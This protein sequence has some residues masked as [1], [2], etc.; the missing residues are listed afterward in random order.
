MKPEQIEQIAKIVERVIQ[1]HVQKAQKAAPPEK[2]LLAIIGATQIELE[3]PLQ[4]LQTCLQEGWNVTI[5]LS[6]LAPKV[7]NL[8][9]IYTTFGE[10]NILQENR[11]T[12]IPTLVN[13][14]SPIVLPVLSYP[15]AGKLALKLAD[16][17]ATYLVF[18][19]LCQG[20]RVIAA[21]GMLNPGDPAPDKTPRLDAIEPDHVNILSK[22][23]V[24]WVT[25]G[26]LAATIS[27]IHTAGRESV[28][29]PVISAAVI[30]KLESHVTELVYAN[31]A[32]VTPLARD[33]AQKRG[34]K[35]IAE[36]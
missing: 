28:R 33:H 12:D 31:P 14:H 25:V 26:H 21:S 2:R 29:T 27:E 1:A 30:E 13:N 10:E 20:K 16:T 35:L 15:M 32:V 7:L 34:I 8:N 18:Q 5:V 19:A 23:G 6:E 4:Q 3:Q 22:F 36:S 11:L 17:P 24:Q 9:P